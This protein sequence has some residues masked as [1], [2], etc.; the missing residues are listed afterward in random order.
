MLLRDATSDFALLLALCRL[1]WLF[2]LLVVVAL[3]LAEDVSTSDTSSLVL[4]LDGFPPILFSRPV[5]TL[6]SSPSAVSARL[7]IKSPSSRRFFPLPDA[8]LSAGIG[9]SATILTLSADE[10][11]DMDLSLADFERMLR[12]EDP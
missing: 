12:M 7:V 2:L 9:M 4:S 5:R 6:V 3:D 10:L 8:A 11:R 1:L